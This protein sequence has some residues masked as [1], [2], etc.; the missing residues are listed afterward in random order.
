MWAVDMGHSW[1]L[2]R[3]ILYVAIMM[4]L[5]FIYTTKKQE[6]WWLPKQLINHQN[7]HTKGR[8]EA[9]RAT[10]EGEDA[11]NCTAVLQGDPGSLK[12]ARWLAQN[13]DYR[14]KVKL[15]DE[16]YINATQ[17]CRNFRLTRGYATWA[18]QEEVDFPLSY[19]IVTHHKVQN[20][21]RLLRAVY[22]PQNVY[23]VHVDAK[24]KASVASAVARIAS[25]FP[26]V[27][28]VSRPVAVLYA[29]WT[30]VQADINCMADLLNVSTAWRY[31][32]NL[33]GQDF[34]LKTN[35]E[36]VRRLRALEGANDMNSVHIPEHKNWRV[37]SVWA[38]VN[39][40]FQSTGKAKAPA[41]VGLPLMAGSAYFVA[42]RGYVHSVLTDSR[43]QEL[44][45]WCKD[46]YSPDEVLWATVQRMPGIP[47]SRSANAKLDVLPK[48]AVVRLVLWVDTF[49]CHGH[50]VREVCVFGVADLPWVVGHH[51]LFA[52]K[53]DVDSDSVAVYCL[54]EY[55]R[56]KRL[57][58]MASEGKTSVPIPL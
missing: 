33:C 38:T 37:A 19:S 23:C 27:F 13:R 29:G 12:K 3:R 57:A 51:H 26:N 17:D 45:E 55:L 41:P 2:L 43:V 46:I 39:G 56:E 9:P 28:L 42:C 53:F 22:A 47:G 34:P 24:A 7:S 31:F 52:N 54:E 6:K 11:L 44:I 5:W 40:R 58:E 18:F 25:C 32:I 36:T 49:E 50:F 20:F 15:T 8:L 1:K 10:W 14:R 48:D 4:T 30:R 16:Y 21:E 35:L